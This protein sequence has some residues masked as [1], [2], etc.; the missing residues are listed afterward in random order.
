LPETESAASQVLSLP[1]YPSLTHVEL[2]TIVDA[3]NAVAK[4]GS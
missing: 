2:E 1:V 3:V 4:A